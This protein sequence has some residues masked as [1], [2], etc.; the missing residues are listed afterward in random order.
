MPKVLVVDDEAPLT[1]L[2]GKFFQGAGYEVEMET[3]GR[4]GLARAMAERP[5]AVL[6][7]IMM[8]DLD[9]YEVCRRLRSDPRTAHA[10]IVIVTARSQPVDKQMAMRAGADLHVIKPFNGKT[11]V[12]E[13]SDL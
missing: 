6:L 3:S 7:D 12:Q 9:G 5:D 13:V 1:T 4:A 10:A 8:P 11:L 2:I